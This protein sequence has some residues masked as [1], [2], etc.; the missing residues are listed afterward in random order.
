M[1]A[2][3]PVIFPSLGKSLDGTESVHFRARCTCRWQHWR[4][5]P[6]E[7][8]AMSDFS[9]HLDDIAAITAPVLSVGDRLRFDGKRTSWLVRAT[10]Q[11]GRYAIA[12]ATL[13]GDV[14]Y[15]I[16]DRLN[17]VRG[18]LNVIGGGMAIATTEGPDEGIN[19][20][21]RRLEARPSPLAIATEGADPDGWDFGQWEVS[22]RYR[23]GLNITEHTPSGAP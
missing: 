20:T 10:A 4:F 21:V 22:H 16:I 19:E 23:V 18:P 7:A 5:P 6:T 12:T 8:E 2:H 13:F 1:N 9:E 3:K 11:Q 14:H 15:T 17:D